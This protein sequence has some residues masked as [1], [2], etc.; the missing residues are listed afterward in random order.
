[1][2]AT[3]A[4]A[5]PREFPWHMP[6]GWWTRQRHYFLY[7]LREF[8]A[9]PMALWLLWLLVEIQRASKGPAHYFPHSS[10][11]FVVFSVIVLGFAL[12]HSYTFLKLAG[13]IIRIKIFDRPI[14]SNVIVLAMFG[15]WA[16]ASVVVG[17]VLIWFSR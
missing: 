10:P 15:T 13:V 4:P 6:A 2:S 8:T 1:M 14:P 9:V 11:G 7:M 16:V 3:E 5:V 12:Y 17:F